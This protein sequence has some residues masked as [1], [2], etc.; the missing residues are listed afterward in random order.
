MSRWRLRAFAAVA[1][2]NSLPGCGLNGDL[3]RAR[4]SQAQELLQDWIETSAVRRSGNT[5]G[6]VQLTDDERLLRD[7]AYPLLEPPYE[8]DQFYNIIAEIGFVTRSQK[9]PDRKA[10]SSHL[11][12]TPYRSQTA[13]YN[14]LI[15]DIRNDV[16]HL[17]PFFRAA[18][19]VAD[20][21]LKRAKSLAYVSKVSAK[22]RSNAVRRMAEN[23]A[24]M[25]WVQESLHERAA[26]YQIALERLVIAAPSP[27]A[28]EAERSLT[29]L[30]QHI[31][32]QAAGH[33]RQHMVSK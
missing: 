15:E 24:I 30:R 10:Y 4:P 23:K 21:D 13:R 19:Q 28:I 27:N 31:G 8:R 14:K 26:S 11:F 33:E 16:V 5:P 22:D 18:H 29:L 17:D 20:M 12:E 1:V 7:L 9:Y 6:Q 32:H 25:R 3:G 2:L